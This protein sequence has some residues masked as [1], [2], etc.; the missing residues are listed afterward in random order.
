METLRGALGGTPFL[1]AFDRF[2]DRNGHRGRYES[3]WSLPRYRED[4]M[5][6]VRA[7]QLHLAGGPDAAPRVTDEDRAHEA[8]AAWTEFERRLS[9]WQRLTLLP[10]ARRAV[11]WIKRYYVWRER[12]RSDMAR[13]LEGL[14]AW[15]LELARRSAARGWLDG[16]DDYFLL[17]LDEMAPVAL[18]TGDP[19][20]LGPIARRR[21]AEQERY[22]RIEMPL[23]MRPSD[24][25]ALIRAAGVTSGATDPSWTPLF[26]LAAGVI[27]EV[28]GTLSHAST[29]ARE[30]GLPAVANVRQATRR[31]RTGERVRLDGYS[32]RVERLD[33][34]APAVTAP[35]ADGPP[36][37]LPAR[38][39]G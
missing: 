32:G 12:V 1:A 11:R 14:R 2:L 5:P 36:P 18:G 33:R 3:D 26:T 7:L 4:P 8:A 29:I 39:S 24:L 27:V 28:G 30:Y 20:T 6:L 22:R 25:P 9:P 35:V 34:A 19:A 16:R 13:V 37:P 23:L 38:A 17:T 10:R 31:L 21:R 15:H